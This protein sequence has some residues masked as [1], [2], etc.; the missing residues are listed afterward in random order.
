MPKAFVIMPFSSDFNDVYN[1]FL[2]ETLSG[3]GYEV[4]RAD[5]INNSQNILSDIISS[6]AHSHLIVADLT[7]ANPNVYYELGIAHALQRPVIMLTQDIKDLP[8]DLRSYRVIPY[9][10]D[11]VK[12]REAKEQLINLAT[13]ALN[14]KVL[15]G[16]PVGDFIGDSSIELTQMPE[17]S[18]SAG[19]LDFVAEVEG[20]LEELTA[21][22][23][24]IA[25]AT[26]SITEKTNK[27]KDKFSQ[28]S[29]NANERRQ[30]IRGYALE[31]SKYSQSLK[32][33]NHSYSSN[34]FR[35]ESNISHLFKD[36]LILSTREDYNS[37]NAMLDTIKSSETSVQAFITQNKELLQAI[38]NT[39]DIER[40][41]MQA[42]DAT[43]REL[44]F[45]TQNLE[46]T[47]SV[48]SR[49]RAIGG[50]LLE[51]FDTPTAE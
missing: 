33:L 6:I 27:A 15:F 13:D 47:L 11:F 34:L 50:L 20:S 48:F 29:G 51:S 26:F 41:F 17:N 31:L 16:N 8:F 22:M 32:P 1:L 23:Q 42:R 18:E 3:C 14:G 21:I 24:S 10:T 30:A 36:K 28:F 39:P 2:A 45:M 46:K 40:Y 44:K 12:I 49:S 19:L 4:F 35:Y 9:S 38:S 25:E 7:G 37:L 43:V 5:D